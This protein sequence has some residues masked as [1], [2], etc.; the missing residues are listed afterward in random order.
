MWG[1]IFAEFFGHH[2]FVIAP[3]PNVHLRHRI[4]FVDDDVGADAAE[5]LLGMVAG[6]VHTRETVN[7]ERQPD[8]VPIAW[9]DIA[10]CPLL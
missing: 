7:Y 5:E 3:I 4:A 6:R 1:Q 2:H 8:F 9:P 10:T